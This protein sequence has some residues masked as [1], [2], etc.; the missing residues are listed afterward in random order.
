MPIWQSILIET[1]FE[2][3]QILRV[4]P[5]AE[6]ENGVKHVNEDNII[7]MPKILFK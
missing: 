6:A 3:E 4:W 2:L 1:R 7:K 5:N